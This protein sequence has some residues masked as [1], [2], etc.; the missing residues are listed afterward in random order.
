MGEG[1]RGVWYHSRPPDSADV[2]LKAPNMVV[3]V[4]WSFRD[5]DDGQ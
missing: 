4:D 2:G 5:F 3:M 1:D